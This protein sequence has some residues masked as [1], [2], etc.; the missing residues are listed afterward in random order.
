MTTAAVR[1]AR[2]ARGIGVGAGASRGCGARFGFTLIELLV[3]ISIIALLIGLL[4]PAL[5][6]A[7]KSARLGGCL[8]NLRQI[9]LANGMYADD[10][11]DNLPI[12][13]PFDIDD[14]GDHSER[15]PYSNFNHGGRYPIEASGLK[16][17]CVEPYRRPLNKYAMPD[18][19]RGDDQTDINDFMD[20]KQYNFPIFECPD[21][22]GY[23]YQEADLRN[24]EVKFGRSAYYACGTSYLFNC[25][26]FGPLSD[27]PDA[28][29]G[30]G[31]DV[32]A[33]LEGMKRF[34]R[35]RTTYPSQ[36][37]GY[38]DDPA[39]YTFWKSKS[40]T[41]PHHGGKDTHSMAFLDGHASQMLIE[42]DGAEPLVNTTLYFTIFP[43]LLD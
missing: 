27:H 6:R 17:F 15:G 32:V 5:T 39:D 14:G 10:H 3:V 21:D 16:I 24:G 29:D 43:E 8:S 31:N 12:R 25:N 41:Y 28:I 19:P 33:Y 13:M 4:L 30:G 40:A 36:M 22:K 20:P 11:N 37:V 23:N 1:R 7:R 35:A 18:V 26:W 2:H 42:W 34:A 38:W 9:T